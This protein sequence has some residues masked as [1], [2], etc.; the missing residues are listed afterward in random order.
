FLSGWA[1][2]LPEELADAI[3]LRSANILGDGLPVPPGPTCAAM[4][5]KFGHLMPHIGRCG[6]TEADG[7]VSF[8]VTTASMADGS[9]LVGDPT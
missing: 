6:G 9:A 3:A 2:E 1:S 5:E 4:R 7:G 8:C